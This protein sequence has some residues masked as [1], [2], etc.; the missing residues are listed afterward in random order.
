MLDKTG[1]HNLYIQPHR[2]GHHQF[3]F[4]PPHAIDHSGQSVVLWVED[5]LEETVLMMPGEYLQRVD[6]RVEQGCFVK[7]GVTHFRLF[8]PRAS[9]VILSVFTRLDQEDRELFEAS[10][11]DPGTWDVTVA[12][13]LHGAYYYYYVRGE[14]SDAQ[15][16]FD[17]TAAVVDPMR[18]LSS[19]RRV[20]PSSSTRRVSP[21]PP[22][23]SCRPGGTT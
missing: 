10:R 17:P 11:I 15:S 20:R 21:A 6:S 18:W 22:G 9:G 5:G 12:R 1:N 7:E 23:A 4:T 3:F 8:A 13:D 19:A 16:A 2:T 14:A